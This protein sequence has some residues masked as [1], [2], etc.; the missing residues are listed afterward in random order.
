MSPPDRTERHPVDA[1]GAALDALADT[2]P[3]GQFDVDSSVE[4]LQETVPGPDPF[5]ADDDSLDLGAGGALGVLR[6][7]LAAS[8]E[9][10]IGVAFTIAMAIATAVGKLAIPV[11]IQQILDRGVLGPEGF[12]PDFVWRAS[13]VALVVITAVWWA[14]RYTYLRLL[15]AAEATLRGLR[16]R[17]FEHIHQLSVADHNDT[18]RGILVARVTSDIET[19]ARF[20][21]WGA[22]AWIVNG[23]LLV[24]TLLVLAVYSWQLALVVLV[25]FLP[26]LPILRHFQRRQ[27][28]AYDLL[29][30][31]VGEML[32]EISESIMGA[33]IVRAYGIESRARGRIHRAIEAAYRARMLAAK[34]FAVIFPVGDMFGALAI[35]LVAGLGAWHATSWGLDAGALVATLFLVNLMMSPIAELG[36]V[37]DQTQ[38]ALAGWRKVLDL[39]DT[40]VEIVEHDDGAELGHH[41]LEVRA[42]G[43]EFAYRTGGR[44]LHGVDVVIPAGTNV[45][46]VG[47][48]GSG[49]TTFAKLLARL[50]DPTAGSITLDGVDLRDIAPAARRRAVR[51][52]PQDGFL[53]DTTI[54]ENVRYGREGAADDEIEAAFERLGLRWWVDRLPQGLDTEVGERGENLSVGERQ[55]VALARAQLADPGLL[56]LDEAT[57]SV[58]PETERALSSALHTLAEGRTMISIAH[59]LSTAEAADLV[60]VFDQG[61]V[62]EA[63]TH[64]ELVAASGIYAGLYA[65]WIGNTRR[66]SAA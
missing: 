39:L 61:R 18:K 10:K 9:L 12:R 51:M 64:D 19:I 50:A 32:T 23:T 13:A 5:G 3:P 7:G 62:V 25:V 40:P 66:G 45:A 27:L 30:T 42:S 43:L 44:V 34:Y 31:R 15:H 28:Y 8:P 20:A 37:L 55:L 52:V 2:M 46:I 35:A 24:A 16:V 59:R 63:G 48:T 6:R 60:L 56:I 36:E 22:V 4:H 33:G 54:R 1:H 14:S 29:R 49:K 41:A 58:D 26:M 17:A 38:T 57:S 53:F 21:Q 11:L 65:S 47:E